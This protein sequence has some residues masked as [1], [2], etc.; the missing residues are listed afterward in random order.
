MLFGEQNKKYERAVFDE[1]LQR[2][3]DS[4]S[5]F[6]ADKKNW[7]FEFSTKGVV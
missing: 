1:Q 7:E 4:E 5:Q 6:L 3:R 2:S